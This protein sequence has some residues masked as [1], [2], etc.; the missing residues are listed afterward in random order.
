MNTAKGNGRERRRRDAYI[1]TYIY[2]VLIEFVVADLNGTKPEAGIKGSVF[3]REPSPQQS[4]RNISVDP[5]VLTLERL[6]ADGDVRTIRSHRSKLSGHRKPGRRHHAP[7]TEVSTCK[8]EIDIT[9]IK[10]IRN[11]R[12]HNKKPLS[13][14]PTYYKSSTSYH[15]TSLRS[16]THYW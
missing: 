15:V 10:Q 4:Y 14:A 12:N 6:N 3:T 2:S 8:T 1:R 7:G 11:V 16:K 9:Q 13:T 5:T